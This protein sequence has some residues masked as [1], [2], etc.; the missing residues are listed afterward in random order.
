MAKKEIR[1]EIL[2]IADETPRGFDTY[3]RKLRISKDSLTI[4]GRYEGPELLRII[5]KAV[6]ICFKSVNRTLM[7]WHVNRAISEIENPPINIFEDGKLKEKLINAVK[8]EFTAREIYKEAESIAIEKDSFHLIP[9]SKPFSKNPQHDIGVF[10]TN[11][12]VEGAIKRLR[13]RA[14]NAE[15]EAIAEMERGIVECETAYEEDSDYFLSV[16]GF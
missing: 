16:R 4:L 6:K 14:F 3:G 5:R 7:A 8:D 11:E 12:H 10:V 15:S 1:K 2:R 9:L 13:E